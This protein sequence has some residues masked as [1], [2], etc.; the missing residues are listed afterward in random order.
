VK[1]EML[2]ISA[3]RLPPLLKHAKQRGCYALSQRDVSIDAS[4]TVSKKLLECYRLRTLLASEVADALRGVDD[5]V[6]KPFTI[7]NEIAAVSMLVADIEHLLGEVPT[8]AADEQA[9]LAANA[10]LTVGEEET[11][12]MKPRPG[13][14]LIATLRQYDRFIMTRNLDHFQAEVARLKELQFTHR[15]KPDPYRDG[16]L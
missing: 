14:H 8:T 6:S 2:N 9:L 4:L 3:E 11:R 1:S 16:D 10:P 13:L 5:A 7:R 12:A 15:D